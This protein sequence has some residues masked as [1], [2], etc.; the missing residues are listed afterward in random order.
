MYRELYRKGNSSS[1]EL[2]S[3]LSKYPLNAPF[4]SIFNSS[5]HYFA[6][7]Y[8]LTYFAQSPFESLLFSV[9]WNRYQKSILKCDMSEYESFVN[10]LYLK[11]ASGKYSIL[12]QETISPDH[13]FIL[14]RA[15][16][17]YIDKAIFNS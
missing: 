8:L 6:W 13:E 4:N 2:L 12:L 1:Q 14:K 7:D 5:N 15:E 9:M 11:D 3:I 16:M 10:N 17:R